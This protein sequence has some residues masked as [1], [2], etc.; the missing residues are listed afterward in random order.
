MPAKKPRVVFMGTGHIG[1]PTLEWLG[2]ANHIQ[3]VGIVT[4]PD[5]P[6]GRHQGLSAPLPKKIG[7]S[8]GLP[9]L[10][11]EKVRQPDA[12][13]TI[14]ALAPDLII[15][16]AYGQ[17][18][19]KVLLEMP[20]QACLNLHASLLP[21]YRGA[22]PIQATILGNDRTTGITSM[23]MDQ[24]LDTG[25]ILL[26]RPI[27]IRR[28]ETGGS[29]HDRLAL[30]GPFVLAE[31]LG[32]L[33]EQ[34]AP[35][36][37]QDNLKATYAPKLERESGAIDWQ[38]SCWFLD[39]QIRAMNPWPGA[40]TNIVATEGTPRRLKVHRA[41]PVHRTQAAPGLVIGTS[42]RGIKVGC[43]NGS[44][45]L[46]EVQLEGKKR[47]AATEFAHGLRLK[48]GTVLESSN[49]RNDSGS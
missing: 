29:L 1:L 42:K 46:L 12:L 21:K 26:S 5:R 37:P 10:Q 47:L 38:N 3:L 48:P 9:V 33:L 6:V 44:L 8:L 30:L 35:R 49:K 2:R 25:D 34:R 18:L 16:M 15:V 45:L 40:Y 7:L 43:G 24:G 17:I 14:A 11:P 27:P 23:Y 28:R 41:L 4:Q 39:R 31:S 13:A 22:A 20:R 19:P 36:I 32:L